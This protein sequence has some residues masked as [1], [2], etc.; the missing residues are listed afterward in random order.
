MFARLQGA[1]RCCS[2]RRWLAIAASTAMAGAAGACSMASSTHLLQGD[3]GSNC[4]GSAGGYYLSRSYLRVVVRKGPNGKPELQP[5]SVVPS[6]D[7]SGGYCLSFIASATSKDTFVVQKDPTHQLLLR[8][9]SRAEDRSTEIAHTIVST[10]FKG[11]EAGAALDEARAGRELAPELAN[12]F[13]GEYDPLNEQQAA[14]LNDGLKDTGYCLFLDDGSRRLK[15][16]ISV[17][18]DNPLGNLTREQLLQKA[19]IQASKGYRKEGAFQQA[20]GILYR[21]RLPYTLYLFENRRPDR[22]LPG[23]W[24]LWQ[25]ET[26]HLENRSP[27]LAVAIDRTYFAER[28]TTLTFDMGVLK[29]V[30]IEKDSELANV[31]TIPLTVADSIAKLPSRLIQVRLNVSNRREELIRAQDKLIEAER[32]LASERGKLTELGAP[33]PRG[34]NLVENTTLPGEADASTAARCE[35]LIKQCMATT[36]G[37]AS[38]CALANDCPPTK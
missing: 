8:I 34:G 38:A 35:P 20:N 36:Q 16:P 37:T 10:V 6:A 17:Y 5:I 30:H 13:E 26:V 9:S 11:L 4:S 32:K 12:A 18:C 31:A 3:D 2:S 1:L 24:V 19:S 23:T 22:R 29:D 14:L 7:R 15:A 27:T 28:K 33:P 21:P 25:A